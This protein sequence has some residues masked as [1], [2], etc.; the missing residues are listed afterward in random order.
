MIFS[1]NSMFVLKIS[2]SESGY[3]IMMAKFNKLSFEEKYNECIQAI[4]TPEDRA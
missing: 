3:D 1:I 4:E 2:Y